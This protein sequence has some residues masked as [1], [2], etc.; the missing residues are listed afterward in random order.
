MIETHVAEGSAIHI[1]DLV[2]VEAYYALHAHYGV[3]KKEAIKA[4]RSLL[5]SEQFQGSAQALEVLA[6]VAPNKPGFV[7]RLIHAQYS[8]RGASLVTFE[9]AGSRL[10]GTMVL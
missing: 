3:P 1:S 8:A 4:L 2:I 7:D 10:P 9:K 5:E 6:H